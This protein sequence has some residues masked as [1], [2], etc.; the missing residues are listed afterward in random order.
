MVAGGGGGPNDIAIS[1]FAME[2]ISDVIAHL[3]GRRSRRGETGDD[4]G[5]P[6]AGRGRDDDSPAAPSSTIFHARDRS[7]ARY[8]TSPILAEL[9][10]DD[11]D[12]DMIRRVCDLYHID[13]ELMRWLGF[14]GVAVERCAR[15]R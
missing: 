2:D 8:A 4:F 14:G 13:V 9:S 6:T 11:C 15:E 1:V 10:V 5:R 3:L 7:D 12:A